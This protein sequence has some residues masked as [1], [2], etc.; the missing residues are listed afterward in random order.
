MAA[1][2]RP[3]GGGL[4]RAPQD[5]R[6]EEINKVGPGPPLPTRAEPGQPRGDRAGGSEGR[7]GGGRAGAEPVPGGG[8]QGKGRGS[9][10]FLSLCPPGGKSGWRRR[11][12]CGGLLSSPSARGAP[13]AGCSFFSF[14]HSPGR[15]GGRWLLRV[16][17]PRKSPWER[18]S[19]RI[20]VVLL[21]STALSTSI[22]SSRSEKHLLV[23][24]A[25][26]SLSSF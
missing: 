19:A 21:P 26:S 13:L 14:D 18:A 17:L 16:P 6:L 10:P 3:S 15:S 20:G 12:L 25:D 8:E 4:R 5:G 11:W 2:R 22:S 9:C 24:R 1:P 23:R 7:D